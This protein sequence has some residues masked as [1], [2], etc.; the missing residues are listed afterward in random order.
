MFLDIDFFPVPDQFVYVQID[1]LHTPVELLHVFKEDLLILTD[2]SR[3][4]TLKAGWQPAN[5]PEGNFYVQVIQH[6]NCEILKVNWDRV[7]FQRTTL[8][9]D[10]LRQF[11]IEANNLV[12]L[13]ITPYKEWI[14]QYRTRNLTPLPY[15]WCLVGNVVEERFYGESKEFRW[16]RKSFPKKRRYTVSLPCGEMVTIRSP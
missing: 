7:F 12:K 1:I 10:E 5:D 13:L 2:L 8:K 14:R 4:Y 16:V 9:L 3:K 11:V 15:I 6:N